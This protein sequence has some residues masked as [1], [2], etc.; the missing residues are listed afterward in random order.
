MIEFFDRE[1]RPA[2]FCDDGRAVY[3]W[4]G[5]PAAVIDDDKVFAYSGRF[6]GWFSDGWI[7][8]AAGLRLLYEFD[9]VGGPA[10]PPRGARTAKGQR[11]PRP[12][13]GACEDAPAHPGPS[14]AWSGTAFAGLV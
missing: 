4:D 9:A 1:G 13:R 7:S 14:S 8:D 6:V 12:P 5:R 11:G 3:H 2:A 10:K